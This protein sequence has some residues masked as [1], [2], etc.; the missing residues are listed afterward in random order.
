MVLPLAALIGHATEVLAER[1]GDGIGGLLN[2]TFA[3]RP[4]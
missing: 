4:N 3:T 1:L 2:A